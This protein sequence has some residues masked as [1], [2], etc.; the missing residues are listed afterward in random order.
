MK[1]ATTYLGLKLRTPFVPSASPLSENLDNLK[2][3]EDAGASAV[4][5]HSLFEEQLRPGNHRMRRGSGNG[6]EFSSDALDDYSDEPDFKVDPEAYVNHI[7]KAKESLRIPVIAS[8]NGA[9]FGGWQRYARQIEQAGADALELNIYNVPTD[10]E[11]S[12]NEIE[13]EYL[14]IVASVKG[15]LKIP[16]A[17]KLS[18]YFTNFSQ[19]ARRLDAQGA[20]A[21]VLFNRFYQPDIELETLEVS[22]N[23]L[24]STPMAMR[25][26]MRWIALLYGRI[27]ANLAATSGIHHG[28]DALKMIMAG[29]DVT[30]L[31]SVLLRHGIDHI[32]VLE[33]EMREWLEDHEYESVEQI[34]GIMSQKNCPD[35]T[36]FERAQYTRALKT[37]PKS[38]SSTAA[39]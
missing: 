3:M 39:S 12:A 23:V 28:V 7:A 1:L 29:A 33:R 13:T 4:V 35:P 11:R 17:V 22:P 20:D 34:K 30:M 38:P 5:F 16:V 6:D 8:L 19:F 37:Y 24:L 9:T 31:C 15:L 36:A 21:L 10:R 14:S 27:G 25:L 26:P 2:R 32:R 18:P